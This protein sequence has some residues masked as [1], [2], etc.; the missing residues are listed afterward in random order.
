MRNK[1]LPSSPLK[2]LKV[3]A[4]VSKDWCP[5]VQ[6]FGTVGSRPLGISM[7]HGQVSFLMDH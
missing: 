3:C 2:E 1:A 6:L 4:Q 7:A 5:R